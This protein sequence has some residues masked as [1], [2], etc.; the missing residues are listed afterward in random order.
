MQ[1]LTLNG[2]VLSWQ[3]ANAS[4]SLLGRTGQDQ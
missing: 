2:H 3:H 4:P 1:G